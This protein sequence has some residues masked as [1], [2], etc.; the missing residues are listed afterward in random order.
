MHHSTYL[1][2][3]D[4]P[5]DAGFAAKAKVP[6]KISTKPLVG[7]WNPASFDPWGWKVKAGTET[8]DFAT[9]VGTA[10]FKQIQIFLF[11]SSSASKQAD[12]KVTRW[13]LSEIPQIEALSQDSGHETID[14]QRLNASTGAQK[15]AKA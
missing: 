4:A 10:S 14:Q 6:T 9:Y 3:C 1:R 15:P 2:C 12:S 5:K 11:H 13:I 7:S 8:L